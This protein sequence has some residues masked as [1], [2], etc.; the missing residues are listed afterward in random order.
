MQIRALSWNIHKCVG[1]DR[2]RCPFRILQTIR[3]LDVDIAILQEVD[4]KIGKHRATLPLSE[5][6]NL[7]GMRAMLSEAKPHHSSGWHGNLLLVKPNI[8]CLQQNT[9]KLPSFEPRGAVIWELERDGIRFDVVGMH[10][11]LL[12]INRRRQAGVIASAIASRPFHPTIVAGDSND[13]WGLSGEMTVIENVLESRP[14]KLKTFPSKRPILS[15]DRTIVGN[16]AHI[17]SQQVI[18]NIK[19]SDHLPLLT[20]IRIGEA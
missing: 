4:R 14:S 6:E 1:T 16:G 19:A 9:I 3:E 17:L 13:W 15:L 8:N 5:I 10:L 12:G 11:G 20:D 7:S 2:Q 18:R